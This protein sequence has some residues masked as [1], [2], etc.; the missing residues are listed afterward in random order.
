MYAGPAGRSQSLASS[1]YRGSS[2]SSISSSESPRSEGIFGCISVGSEEQGYR[3]P[4]GSGLTEAKL[5][6]PP[7]G[8][9]VRAGD[10]NNRLFVQTSIDREATAHDLETYDHDALEIALDGVEQLSL[11]V[12][13]RHA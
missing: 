1:R 9:G 2:A 5:N 11:L 13:Q 7:S 8:D 12:G 4:P 3:H 10:P 6:N